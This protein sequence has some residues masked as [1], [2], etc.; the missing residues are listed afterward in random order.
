M[1]IKTFFISFVLLSLSFNL[2]SCSRIVLG[3]REEAPAGWTIESLASPSDRV[4]FIVQLQHAPHVA[5]WLTSTLDRVSS[6][7][8]PDYGHYLSYEEIAAV[9]SPPESNF[10][11]VESWLA[12]HG[13]RSTADGAHRVQRYM[14]AIHVSTD[15]AS[16]SA[17]LA[18]AFRR[19]RSLKDPAT[20]VVRQFGDF[21]VPSALKASSVVSHVFG[22]SEF[23]PVKS[24]DRFA[25]QLKQHRYGE[26]TTFP[27]VVMNGSNTIVSPQTIRQYYGIPDSQRS[28][29][30]QSAFGDKQWF[31][32]SALSSFCSGNA[33]PNTDCGVAKF[34]GWNC[35]TAPVYASVCSNINLQVE[36]QLDVQTL[37]GVGS[38]LKNS[39]GA[40]WFWEVI[41]SA[42]EFLTE[43]LW[44]LVWAQQVNAQTGSN[45]PLV[46][47]VSYG[48]PEVL[49]CL[50]ASYKCTTL[51]YD[52]EQYVAATDQ[53]LQMFGIRGWT[54]LVSSGDDGAQG[55]AQNYPVLPVSDTVNQLIIDNGVFQCMFPSGGDSNIECSQ[56]LRA[57]GRGNATEL[58]PA[59]LDAWNAYTSK[60]NTYAPGCNAVFTD[61]DMTDN[62]YPAMTS[63]CTTAEYPSVT[64]QS[65]NIRPWVWSPNNGQPFFPDY[66]TSSP[67]VLSVGATQFYCETAPGSQEC[68]GPTYEVVASSTTG[69]RI[70]SGGGFSMFHS[71]PSYQQTVVPAYL[72]NNQAAL[73]PAYTYNTTGRA[74]PDISFNGHNY[75]VLLN[76]NH[77]IAG[78]MVDGTSA[79][80]P[81]LAGMVTLWNSALVAAGKPPLG[82]FNPKLYS[83]YASNPSLFNDI[84]SG[85]IGCVRYDVAVC[86]QWTYTAVKGYDAA[87]GVGSPQFQPV[88]NYLLSN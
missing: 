12:A 42:Q 34:V 51:G 49:Q 7:S 19:Y 81:A 65:C 10:Q 77:S 86:S 38:T 78:L 87:S 2:V 4:L 72:A 27:P 20:V 56:V 15:V 62:G 83:M 85:N 36:A 61:P 54:V 33:L 40:T 70:T 25:E 52:A 32:P 80:A 58:G 16:A 5:D 47:S 88:L 79:S 39:G 41:Q 13:I 68:A 82:F 14:D 71:M 60:P 31:D 22:L 30:I 75:I 8:S 50:V 53:Q 84:T 11:A 69:S 55:F 23:L 66:P 63:T 28:T 18:T 26:F 64:I 74:Y 21:S 45:V 1:L 35:L 48:F 67:W 29:T 57:T 76:Y 46:H 6:P 24:R 43:S 9:V 59:C 73:P 44:I 37:T 17:L 3:G